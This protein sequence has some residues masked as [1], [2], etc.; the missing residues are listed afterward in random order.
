[1]NKYEAAAAA[2]NLMVQYTYR[3]HKLGM[4]T[5]PGLTIQEHASI[6]MDVMESE[7]GEWMLEPHKLDTSYSAVFPTSMSW[8][9]LTQ[10]VSQLEALQSKWSEKGRSY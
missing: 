8:A 1:M 3:M 7:A 10:A 5:S 6:M 9:E 2:M 4:R